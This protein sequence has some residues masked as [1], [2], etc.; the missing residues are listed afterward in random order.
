MR[1]SCA[2]D[3]RTAHAR[4]L[5]AA[6]STSTAKGEPPM[7]E[8]WR[9]KWAQYRPAAHGSAGAAKRFVE[10]LRLRLG[11]S[12]GMR[13]STKDVLPSTSTSKALLAVV[14]ATST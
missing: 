6:G 4:A 7:G 5:V 1:V 9:V 8:P 13:G 12:G 11:G 14:I 3:A 2:A 10:P